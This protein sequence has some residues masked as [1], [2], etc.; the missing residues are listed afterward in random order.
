MPE[1]KERPRPHGDPMRDEIGTD[2]S[3]PRDTNT[4]EENQGQAGSDA[5]P[6]AIGTGG[7]EENDRERG[8]RS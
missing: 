3:E 5:T 6:D 8:H 4:R 7:R 1:E 2:R